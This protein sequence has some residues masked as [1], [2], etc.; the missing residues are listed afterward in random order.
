LQAL[1]DRFAS[2]S[3]SLLGA[4][5][6][7]RDTPHAQIFRSLEER[8]RSLEIP[9]KR[10]DPRHDKIRAE[11]TRAVAD[12]PPVS[13]P[14][15]IARIPH[16]LRSQW[17]HAGD[18]PHIAGLPA[19]AQVRCRTDLIKVMSVVPSWRSHEDGPASA[20]RLHSNQPRAT[21]ARSI[22]DL[23]RPFGS[24]CFMAS[25]RH[26]QLPSGEPCASGAV[27]ARAFWESKRSCSWARKQ[28]S[29]SAAHRDRNAGPSRSART[30][31]SS[32]V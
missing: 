24:A 9:A 14:T 20:G 16:G 11:N 5:R 30:D 31:T 1:N 10:G 3:L 32:R 4:S 12:R 18:T 8:I 22:T 28:C 17:P 15:G 25:K 26:R 2:S 23:R 19:H 27:R 6:R 13:R 7:S 29:M 21:A